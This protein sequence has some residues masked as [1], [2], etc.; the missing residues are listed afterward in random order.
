MA[1]TVED[2]E[3]SEGSE[4]GIANTAQI[5]PEIVEKGGPADDIVGEI[6]HLGVDRPRGRRP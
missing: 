1:P 3:E 5:E 4:S 6:A 2:E